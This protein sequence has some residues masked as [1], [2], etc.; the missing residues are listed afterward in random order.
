MNRSPN[1]TRWLPLITAL[2]AGLLLGL[3][4]GWVLWPVEWTNA[5]LEDLRP[6]LRVHYVA[7]VADAYAASRDLPTALARLGNLADPQG[8][9]QEAIRY[10]EAT[11]PPGGNIRRVNLRMLATALAQAPPPQNRV[12]PPPL[13][14]AEAAATPWWRW[15]LAILVVL[16]LGLLGLWLLR[17]P[18]RSQGRTRD[19]GPASARPL[20]EAVLSPGVPVPETTPGP[21]EAGEQG[22]APGPAP[23]R[24]D[25][26]PKS[27]WEREPH[28]S[29]DEGAEGPP[30][31]H[32]SPE[33]L[34]TPG[35]EWRPPEELPP[36]PRSR[37]PRGTFVYDPEE[38][39]QEPQFAPETPTT[40]PAQA[41]E[42][43]RAPEA[44]RP[45]HGDP[46]EPAD[47]E[48]P[49]GFLR[50][51]PGPS[52]S[53]EPPPD[54][55]ED[56]MDESSR[57]GASG[58]LPEAS[59]AEE[60]G[61]NTRLP[62]VTAMVQRVQELAE[63]LQEP[64]G[65]GERLLLEEVVEYRYGH[66]DLEIARPLEDDERLMGYYGVG[67]PELEPLDT[68]LQR[69]HMVHVW[70]WDAA[71]DERAHVPLVSPGLDPGQMALLDRGRDAIAS[72]SQEASPVEAAPDAR[73]EV[74]TQ[75]LRLEGR[76]EEAAF[77]AQEPGAGFQMLRVQLRVWY[78]K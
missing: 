2:L 75:H 52:A 51:R 54:G 57:P 48:T 18:G 29:P 21:G 3:L 10:Y 11:N 72:D 55:P 63:S 7:A 69:I 32:P 27:S 53:P 43:P 28:A 50:I 46:P 5:T 73:F 26:S 60:A 23:W 33:A 6:D 39:H 35:P 44:P 31:P 61:E 67:T 47:S 64:Q 8:A 38:L 77:L 66:R 34:R 40:S 30:A 16:L 9:I 70:L 68:S 19:T 22:H 12:A 62:L 58:E 20:R 13:A 14:T 65:A 1:A 56:E 25:E 59:S 4:I 36:A 41:T 76:V 24:Q 49:D 15:L 42:A 37:P 78:R 45:D 74:S 71:S 17:R